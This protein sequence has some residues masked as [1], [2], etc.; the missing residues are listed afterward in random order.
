MIF[1][2]SEAIAA[3]G[4]NAAATI[5][6]GA[7]PTGNYLFNT[8]LPERTQ[9]SYYVDAANM[10]V[11]STMAGLVGMDSPYPPGG[12]VEVS[13]FLENSA[14]LGISS[15]LTEG[16]LRQLQSLMIQMQAT[17]TLTNEYL[18][19]EALNF[20]QKIIVQAQLDRAEW[21]RAQALVYGQL[22][23]TFNQKNL[24]V[25][26]GFPAGNFLATRTNVNNDAYGDTNSAWWADL[27]EARRLLRYNLR[28]IV[29][30]STTLHQIMG[31]TANSLAITGQDNSLVTVRQYQTIGGNSVL[32]SDMRYQAEIVIYDEEA[33]VLDT[34]AGTTFG[35]TQTVK[36]MPDGKVLFVGGNNQTGY[37]VGQGST[38]NPRNDLEIGWHAICPTVEGGGLPGRWARLYVPEGR[39]MHLTGEGASNEL[40]IILSPEKIVI[41]TTEII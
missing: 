38:A 3:L 41:A 6:N 15:T 20:L 7:R 9:P 30:N 16:A 18:Q 29:M 22:N 26:Y 27:L 1:N 36:Y 17:G 8:F 4:N 35:R 40:P 14:K 11:R 2:F 12:T 10:V 5:A 24:L 31:N 21:M 34:T 25:N 37:R 32:N 39:P 19:R 28:A 33:E 23:W 13:N